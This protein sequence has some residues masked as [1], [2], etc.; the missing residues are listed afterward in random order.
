MSILASLCKSFSGI[1]TL[2]VGL[3]G[4]KLQILLD[5]AKNAF[6]II[7][8]CSF[9]L[10]YIFLSN[11]N[12]IPC[13]KTSVF[14]NHHY[15]TLRIWKFSWFPTTPAIVGLLT[16]FRFDT[17]KN[18]PWFNLHVSIAGTLYLSPHVFIVCTELPFYEL[19][20]YIYFFTGIFV[21]FLY[22]GYF[23]VF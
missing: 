3:L 22:I 5:I 6:Q 1:Y 13:G 23:Y 20:A 9:N 11:A 4:S 12:Y 10:F 2:E 7:L 16:F 18:E 19:E 14:I 15:L 8:I 17:H 21:F